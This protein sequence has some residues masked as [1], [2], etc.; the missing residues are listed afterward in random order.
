M[1]D[2]AGGERANSLTQQYYKH[3]QIICLVYS[4]D[5]EI[6]LNSLGKWIE[7][8]PVSVVLNCQMLLAKV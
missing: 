6:S 5:S 8:F 3:A 1:F 2:T 7:T 4:V